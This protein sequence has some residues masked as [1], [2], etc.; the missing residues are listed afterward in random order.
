MPEI[1]ND[2]TALIAALRD[3]DERAFAHLVDL[4]GG[5]MLR[6][7]HGYVASREVA[8]D[9]VQE[10]WIALFRGIAKFEGRSSVRTWLFSV[11]INIAKSRGIRDRRDGD[12]IMAA[13]VGASVDPQRFRPS[14]DP[15]WP[16]HWR[17]DAAPSA[18]PD[19]PEGSLL[20]GELI[21]CAQRAT[22][23]LPERQRVVV[24]MRDMLGLDSDEVC[25]L[26][27]ISLGNQRVLLHRGRSV[28]RAALELYLEQA[29]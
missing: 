18:F 8:E 10:T 3:G 13:A 1:M 15:Q 26:L 6:V 20:Q 22:D 16:G 12:A 25:E 23:T 29:R 21:A 27:G 4:H 24:T 7:A 19:S 5:A 17:D 2:E 11:L 28:V 14:N 9:V